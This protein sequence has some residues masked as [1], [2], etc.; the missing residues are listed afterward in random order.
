MRPFSDGLKQFHKKRDEVLKDYKQCAELLQHDKLSEMGFELI[1]S[2][3]Y[4]EDGNTHEYTIYKR[5]EVTLIYT[6]YYVNMEGGYWIQNLY[7]VD[8]NIPDH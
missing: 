3:S 4:E 1:S 2:E 5:G 7:G 6:E 8:G